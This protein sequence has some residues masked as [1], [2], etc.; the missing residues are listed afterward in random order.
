MKKYLLVIA[1]SFALIACDSDTSRNE[2]DVATKT[3]T[4]EVEGEAEQIT[5]E[6]PQN[7]ELSL[8]DA[9]DAFLELGF[10]I[11]PNEKPFF[12]MIMA[13]DGVMFYD[14]NLPVAIYEFADR[15]ELLEGKEIFENLVGFHINGL[16]VIET[17]SEEA[18]NI[19]MNLE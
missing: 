10:E 5:L 12:Q 16:L 17:L 19:F 6:S 14:D 2:T 9:I 11:D 15:D 1:I 18:M 13:S 7:S 4:I 8:D 3:N